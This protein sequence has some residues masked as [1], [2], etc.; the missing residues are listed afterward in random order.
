MTSQE[1]SG[2]C[3]SETRIR[4]IRASWRHFRGAKALSDSFDLI[5]D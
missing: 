5:A 1:S 2:S 4:E 3:R